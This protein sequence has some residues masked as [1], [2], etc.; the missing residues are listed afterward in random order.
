MATLRFYVYAFLRCDGSP[1]YIGKGTGN[2]A[3]IKRGKGAVKPPKDNRRIVVIES[4]LTDIGALAIERRLIRWHGRKDL[5]TGIL[6]NKTDGGDG[7]ANRKV[8]EETR[9]LISINRKGKGTGPQTPEHI[10]AKAAALRGRKQSL[11]HRK[12]NAE[13]KKGVKHATPRNIKTKF[14]KGNVPWNS[15]ISTGSRTLESIR[16]QKLNAAGINSGPQS[17]V[18]CPQCKKTGGVSNMKRYHFDNCKM[19]E[20]V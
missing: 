1:Y 12:K 16:K 2:R 3:W 4:N 6:H 15:G 11:E 17:K 5:G 7:A 20:I 9:L 8:I 13:S 18:E 14:K 10:G 19:K